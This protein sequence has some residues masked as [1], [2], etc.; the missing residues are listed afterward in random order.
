MQAFTDP[1]V[2]AVF[3]TWPQPVRRK[4]LAL[5]QMVFEVAACTPGVGPLEETLKWGQPAY[6][7]PHTRSGSTVRLGWDARRPGQYAVYFHCQTRLVEQF[8]TLFPNDFGF[9]GDR[10]IVL[11]ASDTVPAATL[12]F[13]IA[14]ALTYHLAKK[15]TP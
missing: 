12:Q 15:A 14:M 6:L 1:R 7:T 11:L 2:E 10:A 8:R 5:R 9:E 3:Q 13:C 4:L